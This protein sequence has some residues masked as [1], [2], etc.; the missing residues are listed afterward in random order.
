MS[1]FISFTSFPIRMSCCSFLYNTLKISLFLIIPAALMHCLFGIIS[2]LDCHD[3][4]SSLI[5]HIISYR[6]ADI[7]CLSPHCL[8]GFPAL[9][10]L[11]SPVPEFLTGVIQIYPLLHDTQGCCVFWNRF[12]NGLSNSSSIDIRLAKPV[13]LKACCSLEKIWVLKSGVSPV[14]F[15]YRDYSKP[16]LSECRRKQT[17]RILPVITV[18][19]LFQPALYLFKKSF[20]ISSVCLFWVSLNT[21]LESH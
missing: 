14:S 17:R 19:C 10:L 5:S 15:I 7:F 20:L 1:P 16:C 12:H 9:S 2:L 11:C 3:L 4:T 8:S 21:C 18:S 6:A 13:S